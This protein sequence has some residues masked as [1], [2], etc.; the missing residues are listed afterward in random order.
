MKSIVLALLVATTAS[1]AIAAD[2][3]AATTIAN[4]P[5]RLAPSVDAKASGENIPAGT[6]LSVEIC[7]M[8][9][10]YCLVYG[11]G[12]AVG[13]FVS[14]D[15]ITQDGQ[16][17]LTIRQ[18]EQARWKGIK[19][20]DQARLASPD[21]DSKNIVVWGD[22]LSTGTFGDELQN[23]LIGRQVSMQGVPG[24]D[25]ASISARMLADTS[26]TNRIQVIW[27]RHR[28]GQSAEQYMSE[29]APAIERA[30]A[31]GAA[32]IVVSDVPDL[33]GVLPDVSA[34]TDARETEA[35]NSA[36]LAKYPDN[37]LDMVT[38][39]NDPKLRT[40]GLHLSPSGEAAVARAIADYI[41][42]KGL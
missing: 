37:Y 28:G 17:G 32:F 18:I 24:E 42:A 36:L 1:V 9:G 3:P 26:F 10:E 14:G 11:E 25:G 33:D 21:Y 7:F 16:G 29:L 22:S 6:Q 4:A 39:L 19:E 15:L 8:E 13:A 31:S 2:Y 34:E 23:L 40:D 5:V 35:I 41:I 20:A 30:A 12:I 38:P 27:D